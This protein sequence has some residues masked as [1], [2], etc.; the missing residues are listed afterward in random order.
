M[1]IH[2]LFTFLYTGAAAVVGY[3]RPHHTT[4][5]TAAAL[6]EP[7]SVR[8][9]AAQT[10]AEDALRTEKRRDARW[11][12]KCE[13]E[14]V[15]CSR[16]THPHYNTTLH[17]TATRTCSS[18][19]REGRDV[20]ARVRA[21]MGCTNHPRGD[22]RRWPLSCLGLGQSATLALCLSRLA[23]VPVSRILSFS[24]STSLLS[25]LGQRGTA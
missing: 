7:A 21:W 2:C 1:Y 20:P 10:A 18:S 12:C 9:A 24:A 11:W 15:L 5:Y 23:F 17:Y 3:V 22:G 14:Q 4:L 19:L 13:C 6:W 25:R 16:C 8:G